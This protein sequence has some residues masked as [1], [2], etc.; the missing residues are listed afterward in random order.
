MSSSVSS[1]EGVPRA[2]FHIALKG[3]TLLSEIQSQILF[4]RQRASTAEAAIATLSSSGYLSAAIA[5]HVSQAVLAATQSMRAIM[6]EAITAER[7]KSAH[8]RLRHKIAI[9][10]EHQA[11]EI[12]RQ[13]SHRL[14]HPHHH[15]GCMHGGC[16]APSTTAALT[17][18][19]LHLETHFSDLQGWGPVTKR[20]YPDSIA[21]H[22]N[23]SSWRTLESM[24]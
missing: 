7:S 14:R 21:L 2:T 19:N 6:E 13:K 24:L 18:H 1:F 5:A 22:R 3:I 12:Q 16:V 20:I 17:S 23:F 4:Q 10:L 15:V 8:E 11:K 9:V